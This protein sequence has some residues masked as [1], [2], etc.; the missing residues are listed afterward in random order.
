MPKTTLVEFS[1]SVKC[2]I[3][4]NLIYFDTLSDAYKLKFLF[5]LEI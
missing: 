3:I 2:P 1:V 5:L 4:F